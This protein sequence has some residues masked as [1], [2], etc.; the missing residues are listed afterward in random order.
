CLLAG[1]S[2]EGHAGLALAGEEAVH[3]C[4]VDPGERLQV[5]LTHGAT[6]AGT[7]PTPEVP[8]AACGPPIPLVGRSRSRAPKRPARAAGHP[9]RLRRRSSATPG[10]RRAPR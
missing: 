6:E 10:C 3:H 4:Q 9:H 1:A 7:D 2:A 5:A 8:A